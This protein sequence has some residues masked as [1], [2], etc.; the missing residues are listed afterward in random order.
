M[1]F[2]LVT[3]LAL[4]ATV[5]TWLDRCAGT[6]AAGISRDRTG[7]QPTVG[8]AHRPAFREGNRSWTPLRKHLQKAGNRVRWESGPLT[9]DWPSGRAS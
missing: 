2:S 4:A 8:T 5:E 7:D 3:E 1:T 9:S 6:E